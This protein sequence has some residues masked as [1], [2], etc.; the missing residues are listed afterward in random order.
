MGG[1]SKAFLQQNPFYM[2]WQLGNAFSFASLTVSFMSHTP[3]LLLSNLWCTAVCLVPT[4]NNGSTTGTGSSSNG[5]TYTQYNVTCHT[6]YVLS[7]TS[8]TNV[9]TV[10]GGMFPFPPTC[11]GLCFNILGDICRCKS[12]LFSTYIGLSGEGALI[13][14][15][16]NV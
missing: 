6:G 5:E 16:H 7:N 2:Q 15:P 11:E 8:Y 1:N 14:Q 4:I 13:F 10:S 12:K 3:I 9:C